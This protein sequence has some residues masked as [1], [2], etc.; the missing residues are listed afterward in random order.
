M[1]N[2]LVLIAYITSVVRNA[3]AYGWEVGHQGIVKRAFMASPDNPFVH[4]NWE[5]FYNATKEKS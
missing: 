2:C 3:K 1:I 5:Q 4:E